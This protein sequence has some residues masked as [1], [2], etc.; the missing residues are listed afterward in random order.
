[1]KHIKP[2]R[3]GEPRWFGKSLGEMRKVYRCVDSDL[4]ESQHISMGI[5]IF[6]PGEGGKLHCHENAEEITYV[7]SGG[8]C[9]YG[10]EGELL[11]H[12]VKG[13]VVYYGQGE[14]H[15]HVNEQEETLIL[16]WMHP[17]TGTGP[18]E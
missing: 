6:E 2:F 18:K 4:T 3:D 11:G 14:A 10:E 16:L 5:T 12:F 13:D 9:S 15:K 7:I 1:M 8:G 17:A